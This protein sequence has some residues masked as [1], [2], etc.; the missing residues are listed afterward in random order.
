MRRLR[1]VFTYGN[2]TATIAVV[3]AMSG[4]AV[5]VTTAPTNSVVS[6]SIKDGEV[7]APDLRGGAVTAV[8]IR[9]NSVGSQKV[10]DGSL[11]GTDVADLSVES[12]DLANDSITGGKIADGGVSSFDIGFHA[13]QHEDIDGNAVGSEQ[14]KNLTTATSAG[15]SID[16]G[17]AGNAEV[18]CPDG[19]MPV[20][21]GFAWSDDEPSSIVYS[22]PSETDPDHTWVVRGYVPAGSNT[23]Y[24]WASC[25][26]L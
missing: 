7:K 13:I 11:T 19:G 14:V 10:V 18:T 17:T 16:A 9:A 1:N 26:N 8:K 22:T 2:V 25:L 5:A 12:A 15:T 20:G 21:G 6:S 24:A 4:T 3:L 23:L